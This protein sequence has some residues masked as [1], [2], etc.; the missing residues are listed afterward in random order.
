MTVHEFGE[1]TNPVIMLFPGTMC[2]RR[3]NF[4]DVIDELSEKF[5]VAVVVYT[6]FDESD[7]ESYS[8]VEN[9]LDKIERYIQLRRKNTRRLRLLP[10]RNVCGAPRRKA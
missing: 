8:T 7:T 1:K 5:L 9:E 4:V 3:G 2:Y 10:W 6:G